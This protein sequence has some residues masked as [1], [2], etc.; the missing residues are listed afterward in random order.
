MASEQRY[1]LGSDPEELERL[2]RQAASI[3]RPT[4]Q[5]LQAAGISPGA[6][7]LDLGTGLG[8]VARILGE[9]VGPAGS[10]VGLDNAP[11]VLEAARQR[12][13]AAGAGHVTF[14]QGDVTTW[15]AETP[16]DVIAGRLLLFH[17]ADPVAV[18]RHHLQN[19]RPGGLFVAI[20]FDIGACRTEPPVAFVD[21]VI[22]W[23]QKAFRA[24]GAWPRIGARLGVILEDAGLTRITSFGLQPYVPARSGN[25]A[26]LLAAVTRTLAPAIIQHGI[27]SEAELDLPNLQRRLE[28]TSRAADAVVLLPTVS[29]AWGY[30]S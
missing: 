6:R 30:T 7:A 5:L 11:G 25:G 17:T 24:A 9:L 20:D 19:L 14:T 3:E 16:F 8:H 18:V 28:E 26:A 10:V 21:Q 1:V 2:E 15:R 4:R 23:V 13:K 29:G 12:T 22:G 27:A